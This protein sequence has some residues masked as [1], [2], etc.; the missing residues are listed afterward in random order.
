MMARVRGWEGGQQINEENE[1][2][3]L[4][5]R[6]ASI[7]RRM[8]T[9]RFVVV[10]KDLTVDGNDANPFHRGFLHVEQCRAGRQ[11]D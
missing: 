3:L 4:K 9:I 11:E 7:E 10:T 8:G 2:N 6:F 1:K 5:E